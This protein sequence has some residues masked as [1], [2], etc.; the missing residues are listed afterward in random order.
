M[1]QVKEMVVPMNAN[2][3]DWYFVY[4]IKVEEGWN[5]LSKV[6]IC[7]H[8]NR[9][10]MKREIL[11]DSTTVRFDVVILFLFTAILFQFSIGCTYIKVSYRKSGPITS[12]IYVRPPREL[13]FFRRFL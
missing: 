4:K 11:N 6:R 13:E 5:K 2:V 10:R 7:P 12:T 9:Y 3:V 8:E 1:E